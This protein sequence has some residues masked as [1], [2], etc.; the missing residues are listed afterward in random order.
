MVPNQHALRVRVW[1]GMDEGL[2]VRR[3]W[4]FYAAGPLS[5]LHCSRHPVSLCLHGA[6]AVLCPASLR[7]HPNGALLHCSLHANKVVK[8]PATARLSLS[9]GSALGFARPCPSSDEGA[10]LGGL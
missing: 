9:T 2:D 8:V 10:S 4:T 1:G 3:M 5:I 6:S 7:Q